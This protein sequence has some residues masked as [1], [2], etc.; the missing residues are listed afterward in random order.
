MTPQEKNVFGKLFAKT[1]LA[2]QKVDLALNDDVQKNYNSAIA[3]RKK[4]ADVYFT[5]KKAI[6]NAITE[7][8]SLK[9]INENAL[10]TFSKFDALVKELGIPYPPEQLNQ[11]NNIQ[12]GLKGS[13]AQQIKSLESAKL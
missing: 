8:K 10:A 2:S 6:E 1:E 7:I 9:S 13:F 11:K 4:S 12:D 5:A 3:A